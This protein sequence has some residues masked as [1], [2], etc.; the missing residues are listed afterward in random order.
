MRGSKPLLIDGLNMGLIPFFFFSRPGLARRRR[1][2]RTRR[3]VRDRAGLAQA[4][5]M[6]SISTIDFARW[7]RCN[8]NV[9]L[10]LSRLVEPGRKAGESGSGRIVR[11]IRTRA[12][13]KRPPED[14]G[15][16]RLGS[17]ARGFEGRASRVR[18]TLMAVST[19]S[20]E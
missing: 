20:F 16:A 6:H 1:I 19:M 13:G 18:A 9:D 4:G 15:A 14:V 5:A 17:G 7:V 3:S 11:L 2:E 12:D 10:V 8:H